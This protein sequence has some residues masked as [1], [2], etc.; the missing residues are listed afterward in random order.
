MPGQ[1]N[2]L[3]YE[4]HLLQVN[5]RDT[6][7]IHRFYNHIGGTPVMMIHGAIEDGK[8]FYSKKNQKSP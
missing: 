4:K 6:L 3:T 5:E 7:A 8:I 2:K 1:D